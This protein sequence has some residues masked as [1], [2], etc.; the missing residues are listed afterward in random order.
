MQ[1]S[2]FPFGDFLAH[3]KQQG[4]LIGTDH[5]L[6]LH[7]ILNLLGPGCAPADLKHIL[8]P[9]F[10]VNEKQQN[11]F[12]DFFDRYFEILSL[13]EEIPSSVPP[14]PVEI[15]ETPP[16]QRI[17]PYFIPVYIFLAIIFLFLVTRPPSVVE[18]VATP[19]SQLVLPEAPP[20]PNT[21]RY[22][23]ETSASF[24]TVLLDALLTLVPFVPL[25]IFLY[26]LIKRLKNRRLIIERERGRKPPYIWPL[27]C[28]RPDLGFLQSEDFSVALRHLKQRRPSDI[29]QLDI[30]ASI[31]RTIQSGGFPMFRYQ[32][33]TKP[34]EYLIL[35][36]MTAARD[37]YARWIDYLVD[38]M[39]SEGLFLERYFFDK[40]PRLCFPDY[41]TE[42]LYLHDV[43][44]R[45]YD[46]RLLIFGDGGEFLNPVTGDLEKW[47]SLLH[48][49]PDFVLLTP[50]TLPPWQKA[51]LSGEFLILPATLEGLAALGEYHSGFSPTADH[52]SSTPSRYPYAGSDIGRLRSALGEDVFQWLCACAIFPQL[53]YDL[54]L[55][56]GGLPCMPPDLLSEANIRSLFSLSWFRTGSIPDDIRLELIQQLDQD[57]SQAVRQALLEVL[58][59]N[60]PPRGT[61]ARVVWSLN[62]VLQRWMLE[63]P[64]R[65]HP[66]ELQTFVRKEG[67]KPIQE[68][69]TA[70]KLLESAPS[71]P[72]KLAL[73]TW[74]HAY[75]FQKDL[76]LCGLKTFVQAGL[77]VVAALAL[78]ALLTWPLPML[79]VT[80]SVLL[81]AFIYF[82]W[83]TVAWLFSSLWHA[84]LAKFDFFLIA[85]L[86]II[87]ALWFNL[88]NDNAIPLIQGLG[89]QPVKTISLD[90]A[91]KLYKEDKLLVID[92]R[93]EDFYRQEHIQG[94]ENLSVIF[95]DLMYP[96]LQFK[97]DQKRVTKDSPILVYGGTVSRRFDL[98]LARDLMS[99]GY[100]NVMVL[101]S[102]YDGWNKAFPLEKGGVLA[103][104]AMHLGWAGLLEWLALSIFL[105]MLIPRVFRSP[106]LSIFCRI[107]LGVIFIQFGLSKILRPAVFAMNVAD[108]QLIPF[109]GV[110]L[111]ALIL[112]W[113]EF[114]AGLFLILGI[115]TKA[116]AI[117]IGAL[118]IIFIVG[119]V[120]AIVHGYPINCGCVGETGEPVNWWKV[121]KNAAMLLMTVQI[122]F[123]DR[124]PARVRVELANRRTGVTS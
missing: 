62:I 17:W 75:L 58:I 48:T 116:A 110:N 2:A 103:P 114:F 92:A 80:A 7:T 84:P 113:V 28:E 18:P 91:V 65:R 9:I 14:E 20:S 13:S 55:L 82:R 94:A 79:T 89:G 29:T 109:W 93:K 56:L 102:D 41:F 46:R 78:Y 86:S 105:F 118:N 101:G 72:L 34:P 63:P 39:K 40:D 104:A 57:K 95:F 111:W 54:T 60:P 100:D 8:C 107:L 21:S 83:E 31:Q 16:V 106:Y 59:K 25:L 96:M 12:H 44:G 49:W 66:R 115:R 32:T 26:T 10:A 30:D 120:N 22:D 47:V 37:H 33:L 71:S 51:A 88:Y 4:F 108:Y 53:H 68:D 117:F 23:V 50:P 73:P 123:F 64:E 52:W 119:L 81:V 99:K 19:K 1:P 5:Y 15:L 112:P 76:P 121:L 38:A 24:Y 35:V 90:E 27:I 85:G 70:L 122:F 42:H 61:F 11:K 97:M 3:L 67:V 74:L 6:R 43:M 36:D 124:S 45:F 69:Y 87:F 98:D 77:T